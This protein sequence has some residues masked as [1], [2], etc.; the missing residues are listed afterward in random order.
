M[1]NFEEIET[2]ISSMLSI[3]DEELDDEQRAEMDRYLNDLAQAESDKVDN[4]CGWMTAELARAD[5]CKKEGDRLKA[6]AKT[7]ESRIHWL[8]HRYAETMLAHGVKKIKGEVYSISTRTTQATD[9]ADESA[10]PAQYRIEKVVS[11]IDKRSILADLKAGKEI[12]GARL[13]ERTSISYR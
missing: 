9:I 13:V 10:I 8:R 6:K 2:E 7:I 3:P 4:V 1:P 12:P 5:A 11:D